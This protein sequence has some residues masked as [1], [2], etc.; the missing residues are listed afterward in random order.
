MSDLHVLYRFFDSEDRLLYV[1]I[2][3][4]PGV[5][6]S[7][8]S[9]E[10]TWWIEVDRITL[11]KF[12]SRDELF[13]AEQVAIEKE[14]PIYNVQRPRP[15]SPPTMADRSGDLR[16]K[17]FSAP[18]GQVGR[19]TCRLGGSKCLMAVEVYSGA[20]FDS[21]AVPAAEMEEWEFF[22]SRQDAFG[23]GL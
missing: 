1:G 12:E 19:I 8:H 22:D 6:F 18:T 13:N 3:C 9:K 7:E 5:R 23:E 20:P 11:E 4:R 15:P 21:F 10:K 17:F 2:T 14:N 16:G